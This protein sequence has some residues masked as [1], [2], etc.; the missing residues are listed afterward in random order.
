MNYHLKRIAT[1]P[2]ELMSD[3]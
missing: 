1:L 2:G 3:T